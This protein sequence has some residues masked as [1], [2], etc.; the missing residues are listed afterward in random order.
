MLI[1]NMNLY[2]VFTEALSKSREDTSIIIPYTKVIDI[3]RM[4]ITNCVGDKYKFID[5]DID[6]EDCCDYVISFMDIDGITDIFI[7]PVINRDKQVYFD[8][9]CGIAYID[10]ECDN[11]IFNH[12]IAFKETHLFDTK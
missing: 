8:T 5:I 4:C 9:E 6:D 7:E 10:I 1:E 2:D 3:L 12:L 11:D